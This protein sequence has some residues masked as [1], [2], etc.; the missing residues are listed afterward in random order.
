MARFQQHPTGDFVISFPTDLL[1][2]QRRGLHD[3]IAWVGRWKLNL[4]KVFI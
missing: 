1:I 2:D 3:R 4:S